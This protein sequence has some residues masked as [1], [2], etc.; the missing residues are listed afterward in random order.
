MKG[1][2]GLV[3][4]W[5]LL[6]I[7]LGAGIHLTRAADPTT[8][9]ENG[10]TALLD[11]NPVVSSLFDGDTS[12]CVPSSSFLLSIPLTTNFIFT[13]ANFLDNNAG[14]PG[15]SSNIAVLA[16]PVQSIA[17]SA[18]CGATTAGTNNYENSRCLGGIFAKFVHFRHESAE[19]ELCEV[20][21]LGFEKPPA[22][23]VGTMNVT[24][25]ALRDQVFTPWIEVS[26]LDETEPTCPTTKSLQDFGLAGDGSENLRN[27]DSVINYYGT[28]VT[29]LEPNK[30]NFYKLSL[31]RVFSDGETYHAAGEGT[32]DSDVLDL[33][34]SRGP[35]C[36][37]FDCTEG[38]EKCIER[39]R[40]AEA[41]PKSINGM[42]R[43]YGKL[44]VCTYMRSYFEQGTTNII[45]EHVAE[46]YI[47][48]V[49]LWKDTGGLQEAAT[50]VPMPDDIFANNPSL[51][52]QSCLVTLYN[53]A[54]PG[55][56]FG[57][58]QVQCPIMTR[59]YCCEEDYCF[60]ARSWVN[61]EVRLDQS[62]ANYLLE[63]NNAAV[64]FASGCFF[65]EPY[66]Y[67]SLDGN[68]GRITFDI[69]LNLGDLKSVELEIR[70]VD[71]YNTVVLSGYQCVPSTPF[72]A[73]T[74]HTCDI[75]S[76][77][78]GN[79]YYV[80]LRGVKN[81]GSDTVTM[82]SHYFK[83][84]QD[85]GLTLD[86]ADNS[87]TVEYGWGDVPGNAPQFKTTEVQASAG[88]TAFDEQDVIQNTWA[89]D[90]FVPDKSV[91]RTFRGYP[92]AVNVQASGSLITHLFFS[93]SF[94][95]SPVVNGD[96]TTY[97]SITADSISLTNLRISKVIGS[98]N[99]Q[100]KL[101][102]I[103]FTYQDADGTPTDSP[104]FGSGDCSGF[105]FQQEN[106]DQ[107]VVAF[108]GET[109]TDNNFVA[110]S[111][112][113][114]T[115]RWRSYAVGSSS[116]AFTAV[117]NWNSIEDYKF[118]YTVATMADCA[119]A[120]S[121]DA[122]SHQVLYTNKIGEVGAVDG[123][124]SASTILDGVNVKVTKTAQT[125]AYGLTCAY[126]GTAT[127]DSLFNTQGEDAQKAIGLDVI[128][129]QL[130]FYKDKTYESSYNPDDALT[131]NLNTRIYFG[132][133]VK[134]DTH[135]PM[136]VY[137]PTCYAKKTNNPDISD[138]NAEYIYLQQNGCPNTVEG[139]FERDT[140]IRTSKN[141]ELDP[142]SVLAFAWADGAAGLIYIHCEVKA[143][144][145][146]NSA[147]CDPPTTC[148]AEKR[149]R[150][151]VREKDMTSRSYHVTSQPLVFRERRNTIILEAGDS[152]SYFFQSTQ[153]A[154]TFCAAMALLVMKV[155]HK[156]YKRR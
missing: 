24:Y 105:T 127:V 147:A 5:N 59:L 152:G 113:W 92:S 97:N 151:D 132:A 124:S 91:A 89:V 69:T 104:C 136:I 118:T 86:C 156:V 32:I 74:S 108:S 117:P 60:T 122:A 73:D 82:W 9:V 52:F 37:A 11:A 38:H 54:P 65:P 58:P 62:C 111:L 75:H 42:S 84:Y 88:G 103:G 143:C 30:E 79:E 78:A 22:I 16:G 121:V 85:T 34:I 112:S 94:V 55:T 150:R 10:N 133:S 87:Y 8:L 120:T 6:F 96:S 72:A 90:T 81:D 106:S 95:A 80:L 56:Q 77:Q 4:F 71:D 33:F 131:F 35:I 23:A 14:T 137:A 142:M 63:S 46:D 154:F 149:A 102:A 47:P 129:F 114:A 28:E 110:L 17:Q 31:T 141:G 36:W 125:S 148:P 7:I 20:Q 19:F 123:S 64:S 70:S 44:G 43:M 144:L 76:L 99:A 130:L 13:G 134:D 39:F 26:W 12:T 66:K 49:Q 1:N 135:D 83:V 153:M 53:A 128:P 25:D 51:C 21:I 67:E 29:S 3:F 57:I 18:E 109:D 155:G 45:G 50:L 138:E 68:S 100:G 146:E 98:F 41:S 126:N 48:Y 119:T 93:Y 115:F 145:E 15:V 107:F 139:S 61:H 2:I 40:Q 140:D 116:C 27:Y 101:A